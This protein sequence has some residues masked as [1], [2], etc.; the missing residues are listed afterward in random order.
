MAESSEDTTEDTRRSVRWVERPSL[1]RDASDFTGRLSGRIPNDVS[2]PSRES[3]RKQDLK[4]SILESDPALEPIIP[5]IV[6]DEEESKEEPKLPP[7]ATEIARRARIKAQGRALAEVQG[8]KMRSSL[9][10]RRKEDTPENRK[11]LL[12][13]LRE[14]A[15]T[16]P[17]L[18]RGGAGWEILNIDA[19][20]RFG[21]RYSSSFHLADSYAKDMETNL[22][23]V[24]EAVAKP[25]PQAPNAVFHVLNADGEKVTQ[26]PGWTG[27]V[28]PDTESWR[29]GTHKATVGTPIALT[30]GLDITPEEVHKSQGAG[31]SAETA[32]RLGFLQAGRLLRNREKAPTKAEA[33][34]FGRPARAQD[35]QVY[36]NQASDGSWGLNPH[37]YRQMFEIYWVDHLLRKRRLGSISDP[38][39]ER[40]KVEE[41]Q[42]EAEKLAKA[43]VARLL[44]R[45]RTKGH[46]IVD[47]DPKGTNEA[48][49]KG[50]RGQLNFDL[51]I[52]RALGLERTAATVAQLRAPLVALAH[53][54]V[55]LEPS[56]EVSYGQSILDVQTEHP[57]H[58]LL[59]AGP[60]SMIGSWLLDPDPEMKWGGLKHIEKIR[61]G[62]DF[63]QDSPEIGKRLAQAAGM[64][65]S[66]AF[67]QV[68]GIS[69]TVALALVEPDLISLATGGTAKLGAAAVKSSR[70]R[71]LQLAMEDHA[72]LLR[73]LA[74]NPED[75][76]LLRRALDYSQLSNATK[77]DIKMRLAGEGVEIEKIDKRSLERE[78]VR[79]NK[80]ASEKAVKSQK[81]LDALGAAWQK[82]QETLTKLA[83][84]QG[85]AAART[86]LEL[87][88]VAQRLL[89]A[90]HSEKLAKV[91]LDALVEELGVSNTQLKRAL[92]GKDV[93]RAGKPLKILESV[94]SRTIVE[95]YINAQR[96]RGALEK[97]YIKVL[98]THGHDAQKTYLRLQ[99]AMSRKPPKKLGKAAKGVAETALR[100]AESEGLFWGATKEMLDANQPIS[101]PKGLVTRIVKDVAND[102]AE[103][104]E[105]YL[106]EM[107]RAPGRT[108]RTELD[109]L[110]FRN[111]M[112]GQLYMGGEKHTGNSILQALQDAYGSRSTWGP[113]RDDPLVKY[114]DNQGD[115]SVVLM[116]DNKKFV[117]KLFEVEKGI[118]NAQ[119]QSRLDPLRLGA[120]FERGLFDP[121]AHGSSYSWGVK[122]LTWL[123]SVKK[124]W[125]PSEEM[126]GQ[127]AKNIQVVARRAVDRSRAIFSEIDQL[128]TEERGLDDVLGYLTSNRKY[129]LPNGAAAGMNLDSDTHFMKWILL[130]R[131]RLEEGD[132]DPHL[133]LVVRAGFAPGDRATEEQRKRAWGA[134]TDL[135]KKPLVRGQELQR[136]NEIV[137]ATLKAWEG[138]ERQRALRDVITAVA[139]GSAKYDAIVDVTRSAGNLTGRDARAINFLL[140]GGVE[141]VHLTGNA[142][143]I[144]MDDA[145]R[146]VMKLGMS[147]RSDKLRTALTDWVRGDKAMHKWAEAFPG[148]GVSPRPIVKFLERKAEKI[149]KELEAYHAKPGMVSILSRA[150]G[151]YLSLWRRSVVYGL[152]LPR[153]AYFTATYFGDTNQ[154]ISGRGYRSA[155]RLM[156]SVLPAYLGK[157][158]RAFQ[159]V[160]SDRA[161]RNPGGLMNLIVNPALSDVI[162]GGDEVWVTG[163]GLRTSKQILKEAKEDTVNDVILGTELM[164][165][166]AR[167]A[168]GK[169]LVPEKWLTAWSK[170][171]TDAMED[172]QFRHRL[173]IYLE[174][175]IDNGLSRVKARDNMVEV[176]YDW[177]HGATEFEMQ[178][179]AKVSAFYM[180]WRNAYGQMGSAIL[181]SLTMPL[182][183]YAKRALTGRTKL[184][185][186]R[187]QGVLMMALPEWYWWDDRNEIL[188]DAAML[189]AWRKRQTPW[190]LVARPFL[191]NT[192]LSPEVQKW[193]LENRGIHVT[194]ESSVLPMLTG[195]DTLYLFS[196]M[197][198][199]SMAAVTSNVELSPE[200]HEEMVEEL[201]DK[202]APVFKEFVQ[203]G[204]D[205]MAGRDVGV[206]SKGVPLRGGEEAMLE[207]LG[208]LDWVSTPSPEGRR[209]HDWEMA[210]LT[211][212]LFRTTFIVGTEIPQWWQATYNPK[213]EQSAKAGAM[214]MLRGLSGLGK[215]YAYDADQSHN[216]RVRQLDADLKET[217]KERQRMSKAKYK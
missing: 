39:L 77:A 87:D 35:V 135:V 191:T 172:L 213:W 148:I 23:Q 196:L 116:S 55:N 200:M 112:I 22:N 174:D 204:L 147:I 208:L 92:S 53:P 17:D 28:G 84:E 195:L 125:S 9:R 48:I 177:A 128:I 71:A 27:Q 2:K 57:M 13:S 181:E 90:D 126:F 168:A 64:E 111:S 101:D 183:E 119:H 104:L 69:A 7:Q 36:A 158:G 89:Q 185:R 142:K 192:K 37:V 146:A 109:S 86:Q 73:R 54:T 141:E 134:I 85:E 145:Y 14:T 118:R 76:K 105:L 144:S 207:A 33:F 25:P 127:M 216:Y 4:D 210:E 150:L 169:E 58:W 24:E 107:K 106:E 40:E 122:L 29:Q 21:I 133:K 42:A 203:Y 160:M 114:L 99:R 97:D 211:A 129:T 202:L 110:E 136:L 201:T 108:V 143:D 179:I 15:R 68:A 31:I 72:Q 91:K 161:R 70:A 79:L 155:G 5:A 151:M 156:T 184:A 67:Q 162:R 96:L 175:R 178:T 132:A 75:P 212:L 154:V 88:T 50:E 138:E 18:L 209:Y 74:E 194:H 60:W 113:M 186:M 59:R 44:N 19:M 41:V 61:R 93:T 171:W 190:W 65:D 164:E 102:Q 34:R 205:G 51:K 199:T 95:D 173:S 30:V 78:K 130:V 10:A 214:E 100:Q 56:G 131:S 80:E 170:I 188:E 139:E 3:V 66:K 176:A 123:E 12:D 20:Q 62:Y 16:D 163:D 137:S 153:Y 45:N 82:R 8:I 217:L 81:A 117:D 159:D 187:Q 197:A 6:A 140:Q 149:T 193:Y 206:R 189:E 152:A 32:D 157:R 124:T 180:F 63:T 103:A 198:Q 215:P 26:G 11:K 47:L 98:K 83:K 166:T 49:V 46:V 94:A 1:I 115:S 120:I 167:K 182:E 38:T 165:A 52:L 43:D 121:D